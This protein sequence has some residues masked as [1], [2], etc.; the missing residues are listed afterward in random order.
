MLTELQEASIAKRK[1]ILRD[2]L[3]ILSLTLATVVL[4]A[5]TLFLFRSFSQHRADLAQQAYEQGRD[6]LDAHHPDEAIAFLRTALSYAPEDRRDVQ[7]LAQALGETGRPEQTEESY[8]YFMNLWETQ[9]G[10]GPINLQLARLSA[11]R[12]ERT[13]AVNFYRAAVY[14]TWEGDGVARRVQVRLELAQYFIANH[15][16]ASARLELLIAGGNAPDD[17]DRDMTLGNLLEQAQDP[18]DASTYYQHAL[19]AKPDDPAALEAAGRLAYQSGDFESAHRLLARAF[20]EH[21]V[22]HAPAPPDDATL[23]DNA[24]RI[25]ELMPLPMLPARERVARILADR[26]IAARRLDSCSAQFSDA[27]ELP[28]ALQAMRSRWDGTEGTGNAAVLLRD[29]A[30]QE[31][32][33]QLVYDTE[34]Q[35]SKLC[36]APT[37]DD[38]LLMR[39]STAPHASARSD[40]AKLVPVTIPHD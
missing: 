13:A 38:A 15:D 9:P 1:L 37:G 11:K 10:N 21:E 27:V 4:F 2:S 5:I 12:N 28:S 8:Q 33:M 39:M 31:S 7:L 25:L 40:A 22:T 29:P 19:A 34:T 20:A 16:L 18:T 30:Q 35:T 23:A 14:G 32:A 6:A 36:G 26:A 3:A 24:E 17:F